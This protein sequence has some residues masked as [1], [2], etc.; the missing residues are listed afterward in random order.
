MVLYGAVR[1]LT[2]GKRKKG[3]QVEMTTDARDR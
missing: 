1:A 2:A 3:E